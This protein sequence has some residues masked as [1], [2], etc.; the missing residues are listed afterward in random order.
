[1]WNYSSISAPVLRPLPSAFV[2]GSATVRALC[3]WVSVRAGDSK[4]DSLVYRMAFLEGVM[5]QSD[6]FAVESVAFIL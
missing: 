3:H 6:Q 1:M 5:Q 4:E 2:G